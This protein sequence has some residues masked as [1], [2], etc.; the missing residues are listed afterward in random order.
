MLRIKLKTERTYINQ[1]GPALH[2]YTYKVKYEASKV[3]GTDF[4][5]EQFFGCSWINSF[6]IKEK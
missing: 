3:F 6:K 4:L 1:V 5:P 2:T